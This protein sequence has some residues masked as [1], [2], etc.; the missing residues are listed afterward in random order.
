MTEQRVLLN[1]SNGKWGALVINPQLMDELFKR[2]V[3]SKQVQRF[4]SLGVV[5]SFYLSLQAKYIQYDH[6]ELV[7]DGRI[8]VRIAQSDKELSHIKSIKKPEIYYVENSSELPI[9]LINKD[10][11]TFIGGTTTERSS[12]IESWKFASKEMPLVNRLLAMVKESF[13]GF[14]YKSR[15]SGVSYPFPLF[16]APFLNVFP[17]TTKEVIGIILERLR[18]RYVAK[19]DT[20]KVEPGLVVTPNLDHLRFL[21][22]EE[23]TEFQKYYAK[24]FLQTA[25]GYPPLVLFGKASIGYQ[26]KEVVTGVEMFVQLIN[27]IGSQA[28]PYTIYIV[29]GFGNIPYKTRD[30]FISI[31]PNLKDNFVGIST[32]PMGFLENKEIVDAVAKD[33]HTKK[34]DIIFAGMTVPT[35]E[36]FIYELMERRVN[37]GLGFCFGRAIEIVAGYQKKEP[38]LIEKLHLSWIYRMIFGSKKDIKV[39]Q[40]NRVKKDFQF[41]FKT[42]FSKQ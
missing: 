39:R 29:G 41:V 3:V 24:S 2:A 32:P 19:R 35:Q 11:I 34:P 13:A 20:E 40:R 5:S 21:F 10:E 17:G 1:Q 9:A 28:L 23:N 42:L 36:R 18:L 8:L 7:R 31:Y 15:M 26:P 38:A 6:Q 14:S 16:R 12:F 22:E 30:Y 37:F 4:L 25:D 33:I 27:I